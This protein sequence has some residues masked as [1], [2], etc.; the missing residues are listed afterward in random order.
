ML[1]AYDGTGVNVVWSSA[2]FGGSPGD[3]LTLSSGPEPCLRAGLPP[4]S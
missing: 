3:T 2:D 1:E 4:H